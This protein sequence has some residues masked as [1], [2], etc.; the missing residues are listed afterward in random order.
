VQT[1]TRTYTHIHTPTYQHTCTP[2]YTYKH[3]FI[4]TRIHLYIYT[5]THIYTHLYTYTIYI[6]LHTY[7][8]S[9][10][11]RNPTP[12][13]GCMLLIKIRPTPAPRLRMLTTTPRTLW[14]PKVHFGKNIHTYIETSSPSPPFYVLMMIAWNEVA[15]ISRLFKLVSLFWKR[16]LFLQKSCKGAWIF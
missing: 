5:F 16:A 4:N 1:F 12:I 9:N 6:P 10:Y 14:K 11:S 2:T 3:A 7:I 15:T 8:S 13:L